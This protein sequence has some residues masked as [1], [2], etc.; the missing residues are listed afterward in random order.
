VP[1]RAIELYLEEQV[2]LKKKI[3]S[4]AKKNTLGAGTSSDDPTV[5]RPPPIVLGGGITNNII[6][7]AADEYKEVSSTERSLQCADVRVVVPLSTLLL[8]HNLNFSFSSYN[9]CSHPFPLSSLGPSS[10]SLLLSTHASFSFLSPPSPS[11]SPP[12]LPLRTQ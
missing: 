8:L 9:R 5:S 1:P 3:E 4:D 12:S 6:K 7:R 11:L 2:A 10:L